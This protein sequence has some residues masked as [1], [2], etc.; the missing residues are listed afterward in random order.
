MTETVDPS[1]HR[2]TTRRIEQLFDAHADRVYR[3]AL[4]RA[5]ADA[6]EVVS[7]TFLVAW[8]R[9]ADIPDDALPWLLGV[10]RRVLANRRRADRRR[11]V[12]GAAVEHH[13]AAPTPDTGEAVGTRAAVFAAL[14]R[15]SERDRELLLLLAWDDL[16]H[17]AIGRVVG[18][19]T[20]AVA[21][22][23]HRARRRFARELERESAGLDATVL[24]PQG[25]AHAR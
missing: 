16:D 6:D 12:L 4:R 9:A 20:G 17:A 19:S 18:C 25:A 5:P 24:A 23:L 8:R 11:A 1:R 22:R 3:Y 21:V 15:L 14:A 2:S 10:A 13:R 7:E